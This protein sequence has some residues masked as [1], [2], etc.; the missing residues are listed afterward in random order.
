[1]YDQT[2][3][4][5]TFFSNDLLNASVT[6]DSDSSSKANV[7]TFLTVQFSSQFAIP[8]ICFYDL[9]LPDGITLVTQTSSDDLQV[10]NVSYY[11]QSMDLL[12]IET[13]ESDFQVRSIMV[14]R[15][16]RNP[17]AKLETSGTL[18]FTR[19]SGAEIPANTIVKFAAGP[20]QRRESSGSTGDFKLSI[21]KADGFE[22]AVVSGHIL[23]YPTPSITAV[24]PLNSRKVGAVSMTVFGRHYGP[25][26]GDSSVPGFPNQRKVVMGGM[27]CKSVIWTSDSTIVCLSPS[28]GVSVA[29]A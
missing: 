14:N 9:A 7:S 10:S 6:A 19:N 13:L 27:D 2:D 1:M 11:N 20:F 22:S 24:L 16:I 4:R 25:I 26:R 17:T 28:E 3:R 8:T 21:R 29:F 18:I 5:M 23:S 15:S 12:F